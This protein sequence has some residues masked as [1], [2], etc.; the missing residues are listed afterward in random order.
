MSLRIVAGTANVPLATAVAAALGVEV[1]P[2]EVEHFP[3]GEIR[4]T[5]SAMRGDD[6]YVV[7]PIGAPVA[8]NLVE[9]VDE[10]HAFPGAL[11]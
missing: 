11:D 2:T 5:V 1:A 8:A 10:E 9:L 6:V 7:Q 3:D 4:P